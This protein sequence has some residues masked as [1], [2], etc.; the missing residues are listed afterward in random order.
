MFLSRLDRTHLRRREEHSSYEM[1]RPGF[2]RISLPFFMPDEEIAFVLE[3]LKMVATEGWK[4]LP[5]YI[6]N[7]ETGEWRHRSNLVGAAMVLDFLFLT[8]KFRS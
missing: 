4:L 6:L 5:Q 2:A 1:L 3:A 8:N 7:P